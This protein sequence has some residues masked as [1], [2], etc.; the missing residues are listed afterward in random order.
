[1]GLR[2]ARGLS[3]FLFPLA[4]VVC[5][6]VAMAFAYPLVFPLLP[7]R[8]FSVKG[9]VLESVCSL[10]PIG[11]SVFAA[12]SKW[13]AL[14]WTAYLIATGI[15]VGLLYTGNSAVSNA[16]SVRKEIARFLPAVVVLYLVA[17]AAVICE[18]A[19]VTV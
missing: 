2:R 9:I 3:C 13:S 4:G 15:F 19:G 5:A 7:T 11:L 18:W 16:T 12:Y 8:L 10:V 6:A 17:L 14:F 1:M